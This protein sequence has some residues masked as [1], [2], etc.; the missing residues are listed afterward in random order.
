MQAALTSPVRHRIPCLQ[1]RD[2]PYGS[3]G[4]LFSLLLLDYFVLVGKCWNA[5]LSLG[6]HVRSLH[7]S[8]STPFIIFLYSTFV[9]N[10][11]PIK[12]YILR[13]RTIYVTDAF[14]RM[15]Y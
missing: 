9:R 12:I 8:F 2:G 11:T 6:S 5:G 14:Q 4:G 7:L 15:V 1:Q 10:E 13:T 3:D